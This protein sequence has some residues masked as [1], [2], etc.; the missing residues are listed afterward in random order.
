MTLRPQPVRYPRRQG[1]RRLLRSL[2]RMSLATL[3]DFEV[4]GRHNLPAHGPLIVVANHF[5]FLDPVAVIGIT[6]WPMEFL[7]GYRMPNAPLITTIFP[8]LWGVLSVH[9]GAVS[10]DALRYARALLDQGGVLGVFPEAGSWAT[11]LRP[12]RPGAAYLAASSGAKLLPI[13]LTGLTELFPG[14]RRGRRGKITAH[15]G[16][17]FGPFSVPRGGKERRRQLDE[18]G[19]R[20]M[21]HIADL[22]PP[23]LR[24]HYS[25]DPAVRAAAQGTEIYPW[26]ENP[27]I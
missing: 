15:I 27:D 25:K 18:I 4:I 14:L 12:A 9:R 19:H 5:S 21:E 17:P 26:A 10:R 24:G 20:I 1:I 11:V 3:A 6:D 13:G 23:E 2:I 7:A 22:I 16:Q 8:R